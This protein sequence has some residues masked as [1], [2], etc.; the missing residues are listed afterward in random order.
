MRV[1][2]DRTTVYDSTDQSEVASSTAIFDS[3]QLFSV[4]TQKP[5]GGPFFN[6]KNQGKGFHENT[7]CALQCAT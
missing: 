5:L 2:L 6:Q 1:D 7:L 3:A 4:A